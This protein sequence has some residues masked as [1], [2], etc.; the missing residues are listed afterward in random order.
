MNAIDNHQK[1][2]LHMAVGANSPAILSVLLEH[3]ADA[4]ACDEEGNTAM[5]VAMQLG[6]V[7]CVK[8]LIQESSVNLTALNNRS[9]CCAVHVKM[10]YYDATFNG[11][12][13]ST[14]L[15]FPFLNVN[16]FLTRIQKMSSQRFSK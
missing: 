10:L 4:D 12:T 6:Q 13:T 8:V 5:H 9:V 2:V 3:G 7:H 1:G 11:R 15:Q 14:P 16:T